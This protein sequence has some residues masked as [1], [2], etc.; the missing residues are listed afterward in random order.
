MKL[1]LAHKDLYEAVTK[2]H[3]FIDSNKGGE[4]ELHCPHPAALYIV[5]QKFPARGKKAHHPT[6]PRLVFE[7]VVAVTSTSRP[8]DFT[9]VPTRVNS[10]VLVDTL[11]QH[12]KD[13]TLSL[14]VGENGLSIEAEELACI[15]FEGGITGPR[16]KDRT[17]FMAI[18]E[19]A[20]YE[21]AKQVK[22]FTKG[23]PND[24]E[25]LDVIAN[26][27]MAYRG[28]DFDVSLCAT[29]GRVLYGRREH[30]SY[31]DSA[32]GRIVLPKELLLS[33]AKIYANER[34]KDHAFIYT[35]ED[36]KGY[37]TIKLCVKAGPALYTLY[38]HDKVEQRYPDVQA[39]KE[40]VYTSQ[41]AINV[42]EW[43][44][45]IQLFNHQLKSNPHWDE[46]PLV[47][48]QFTHN[49]CYMRTAN[50]E[51]IWRM[52]DVE[53]TGEPMTLHFNANHLYTI[54]KAAWSNELTLHMNTGSAV[55][56]FDTD[57]DG[58]CEAWLFIIP[59]DINP[60]KEVD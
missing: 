10:K 22:G 42:R 2:A 14:T 19:D 21:F 50:T 52:I 38:V 8:E 31:I 40:P 54:L 9:D 41:A 43:L 44:Q 48:V 16:Q 39:L 45:I 36:G 15:A 20:L 30:D 55:H 12:G 29:N 35:D 32:D 33:Y 18:R 46:Q 58:R 57:P 1:E 28:V 53:L 23:H 49:K 37:R 13:D 26:N 5:A 51:C 60:P 11:K 27:V 24:P 4:I 25:A 6:G 56:A 59:V 17:G 3:K 47:T 7:A 34:A